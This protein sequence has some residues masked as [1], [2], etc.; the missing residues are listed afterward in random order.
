MSLLYE[1]ARAAHEAAEAANTAKDRF[2]AMLSHELRTP[3]TPVLNTVAALQDTADL[4]PDLRDAIAMIRRN[5]ELEARLIDD[6]LDLTRIAK[7]KVR[8][9]LEAV[10]AH[11]LI[12][13][14]LDIC[15]DDIRAKNLT[16]ETDLRAGS[17]R[18]LA[19][20]ARLHQVFW[21]L[22]KNAVKFT[23][24]GGRLAVRSDNPRPGRVRFEVEDSGVGIP[25]EALGK[26]F[27][28]F[29]QGTRAAEGGLGLGLAITKAIVE[30]HEGAIAATSAGAG[31]GATFI[32]DLPATVDG[33]APGTK[34]GAAKVENNG[35]PGHAKA[36]P[37]S[38][39]RVLV[40]DDHADTLRSLQLLLRQRGY[41]VTAAS[42][43]RA[44]LEAVAGDAFDL[45]ISDVGL[46]D[47]SGMDLMR[48]VRALRGD[49]LPGIALSGYGMEED[50][51]RSQDAGF[52]LHLTKPVDM[53]TLDAAMRQLLRRAEKPV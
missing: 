33:A 22:L 15:G 50:L 7:G 21:N 37:D 41:A 46:P 4:P 23:P 19:D 27:D 31:R 43:V 40:V 11:V 42:S 6:L 2:L 3:L 25:A 35:V 13:T 53:A 30:L 14:A 28:A 45:L 36:C 32:L 52:G 17:H 10:D 39:A 44:A 47:G 49:A 5:V 29:E 12:G 48:E 34:G 24:P 38:P 16:V 1:E 26:I 9:R 8:L 51:A 18:L 20:A